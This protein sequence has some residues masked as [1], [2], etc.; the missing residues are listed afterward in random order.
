MVQA[1]VCIMN[2]VRDTHFLTPIIPIPGIPVDRILQL[3]HFTS[4]QILCPI[5]SRRMT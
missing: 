1:D 3:D 4:N 5:K 2:G